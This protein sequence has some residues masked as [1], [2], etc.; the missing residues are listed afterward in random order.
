[1]DLWEYIIVPGFLSVITG[2][3]HWLIG[4]QWKYAFIM[5][6]FV[7]LAWVIYAVFFGVYGFL[8]LS[9]WLIVT[10]IRSHLKLCRN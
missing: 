9:C 10:S 7:N 6:V 2:I 5:G 1:M 4:D 8:P 3:Q